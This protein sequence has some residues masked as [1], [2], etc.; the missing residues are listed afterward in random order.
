MA[1]SFFP[2]SCQPMLAEIWPGAVVGRWQE[3]LGTLGGGRWNGWPGQGRTELVAWRMTR[4]VFL[5]HSQ[6]LTLKVFCY[7]YYI[8]FYSQGLTHNGVQ[9]SATNIP[10]F[11]TNRWCVACSVRRWHPTCISTVWTRTLN[12]ANTWQCQRLLLGWDM[13]WDNT[14]LDPVDPGCLMFCGFYSFCTSCSTESGCLCLFYTVY[15][16]LVIF[17]E[18][19]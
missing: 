6:S 11:A 19:I 8:V 17:V 1:T 16:I 9:Q 4:M 15:Y 18:Y 14:P 7:E 10:P 2:E 3:P 12:W 13:L 5:C